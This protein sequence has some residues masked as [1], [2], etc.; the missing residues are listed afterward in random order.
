[1]AGP[2]FDHIYRKDPQNAAKNVQCIHTSNNLGTSER[3]CHQDW[4][5]GNCGRN[6]PGAQDVSAAICFLLNNCPDSI[7]S[8]H[9]LCP[10]FYNSAF[11]ND[12]LADTKQ[13]CRSNRIAK[14]LPKGFKMGCMESRRK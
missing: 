3:K 4:L 5:M 2:G 11:T 14:N 8:S 12:F 13:N 7:M 9:S 10:V 6:Q 1:M